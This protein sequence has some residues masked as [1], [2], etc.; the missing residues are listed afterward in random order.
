MK[1]RFE[2]LDQY[3]RNRNVQID[4]V[5]ETKGEAMSNIIKKVFE[6]LD[7]PIDYELDIQ[8]GHRVPTQRKSGQKPIIFQFSNR[9]KRNLF[10]AKA[11]EKRNLLKPTNFVADAP[12]TKVYI[13]EHL[14]IYNKELFEFLVFLASA[15]ISYNVII[16]TEIWAKSGEEENYYIPGY[17]MLIEPRQDNQAGGVLVYIDS[18]LTFDH[19]PLSPPG[20]PTAEIIK[21]ELSVV[22][23]D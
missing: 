2:E 14:T 9:Q 15:G 12:E 10:L 11:K 21:L 18:Q 23:L 20:L 4:G 8:A 7:V 6:I 5:P 16:L 17:N 19:Q 1:L 22:G 13:N 3:N